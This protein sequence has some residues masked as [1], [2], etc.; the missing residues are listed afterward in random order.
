MTKIDLVSILRRDKNNGR[1]YVVY[2]ALYVDGKFI[3]TYPDIEDLAEA[4]GY[5]VCYSK[6]DLEIDAKIPEWYDG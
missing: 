3:S 6:L 5:S 2:E 1:R 4:L